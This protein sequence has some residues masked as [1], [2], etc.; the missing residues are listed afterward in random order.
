MNPNNLVFSHSHV[1][2]HSYWNNYKMAHY[3]TI[4]M[5]R[6]RK[7]SASLRGFVSMSAFCISVL[8][9]L[10]FTCFDLT[11]DLKWWYFREM[12]WCEERIFQLV[13]SW[14]RT[15]YLHE[16]CRWTQGI[17]ARQGRWFLFLP[18]SSSVESL[19]SDLVIER[20]ILIW[21]CWEKSLF[22]ALRQNE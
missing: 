14:Y 2:K 17:Q 10:M 22:E 19:R 9:Y 4:I 8:Q 18:S 20:C 21:L 15:G 13:P 12:C 1:T 5:W 16:Q 11:N 3:H 6:W 7:N